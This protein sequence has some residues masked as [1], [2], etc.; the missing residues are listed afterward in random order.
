M[1]F[2][3]NIRCENMESITVR[4]FFVCLLVVVHVLATESKLQD[5][6]DDELFPVSIIHINDFHARYLLFIH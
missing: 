5:P 3:C 4:I 6:N 2:I 1:P